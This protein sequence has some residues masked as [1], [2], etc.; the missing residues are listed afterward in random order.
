MLSTATYNQLKAFI[1]GIANDCLVD[2]YDVGDY[3]KII[4]PMF[5][6]R[7]LDAVLEDKH[8]EVIAKKKELLSLGVKDN[9]DAAL[10]TVA[11]Q[12]FV[13][14]SEFTL[15][16]LKGISSKKRLKD[17]FIA[18]LDGFSDNVQVIIDKFHIRNEID[19]LSEQDRLGM[20]IEKFVDPKYNFS[21]K[22][23]LNPDGSVKIEALDNHSMGT[24][25]EEVIRMFNEETNVTDAGRHFTP[26]D[27]VELI[28]DLAFI[29]IQDKIKSTS[30]RI[31]DGACGT[32]G[33]LTVGE[34]RILDLANNIDKKV[35]I[36]LFGQENADETYAIAKADMLVKGEGKQ[37]DNI[38]FG[39]TISQDRYAKEQFDFMLSNPPFGTP[40][41]SDLKTY[42]VSKK[43]E[44]VD[45]RFI[46]NYDD[47]PNFSFLPDIGDP[48]M[49]FLANNIS[50]MKTSTELGSRI[51]E[52]HNG[53]ALFTG[54][55]GQGA[56]NLRRYIFENDLLDAIVALPENLFYNTGIGTYLWILS[57]KKEERRKGKVQLIDATS[58]KSSLRKNLGNKNCEIPESN[59]KEI[60]K[61]YMDFDKA[62]KEKSLV[63][64]NKEFG[65]VAIDVLVS[66]K[67]KLVITDEALSKLK[68]ENSSLHD[69]VVNVLK[70]ENESFN[71]FMNLVEKQ[72][73]KEKVKLPAKSKKLI[74]EL[75]TEISDDGEIVC[76]SKGNPEPNKDL[77][78][79]E[80]IPLLYDGGIEK[81]LKEEILPY[82]PDAYYDMSSATIGYEISFSKYF[83][84]PKELRSLDDIIGDIEE[85]EQNTDGLLASILEGLR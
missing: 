3:R 11:G 16:D 2:V 65:H 66:L 10:F 68:S 78:D 34:K 74:R 4:L 19:R 17:D 81:Y 38:E 35:S 37:A 61:L 70:A 31:Y 85:I 23:I 82:N 64:D 24:L 29:P 71:R 67:L 43:E 15:K 32:G 1:W 20:I 76:D 73:K 26:R 51:V 9:L 30:Y 46:I 39:S 84:K 72:A 80:I 50:K 45:S 22:D 44:I 60:V 12:A 75:F 58:M 77:K 59:R 48:Q 13:N 28:A 5:V 36:N 14:K 18:Y 54:K 57:N 42:G 33:M 6:I 40:W 47:N 83:Y 27:I 7:R 63:L 69:I 55:A 49:L 62:D 21:N 52:V 56:S 41:K 79:T 8:P 25:F 53:S